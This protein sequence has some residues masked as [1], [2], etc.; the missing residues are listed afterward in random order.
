MTTKF[1]NSLLYSIININLYLK[2]NNYQLLYKQKYISL[3]IFLKK[4]NFIFFFKKIKTDLFI[5]LKTLDSISIIKNIKIYNHLKKK[6]TLKITQVL[7]L[8]KKNKFYFY[9]FYNKLGFL[10]IEDVLKS[11]IG[12]FLIAKIF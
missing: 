12:A 10:T 5:Y 7:Q 4:N 1:V 9:I 11:K 2:K 8:K 3:L 6:K